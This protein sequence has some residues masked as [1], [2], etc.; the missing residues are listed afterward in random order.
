MKFD[1]TLIKHEGSIESVI[2]FISIF[3]IFFS[4][5]IS[6]L[7]IK[8]LMLIFLYF[9]LYF[10]IFDKET[11]RSSFIYKIISRSIYG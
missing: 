8:I 7:I 4:L 3:G 6:D 9:I 2:I 10:T 1:F 5:N 11:L